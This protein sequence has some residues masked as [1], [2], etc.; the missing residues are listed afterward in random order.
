MKDLNISIGK[1]V[2]LTLKEF[3]EL[4]AKHFDVYPK[5]LRDEMIKKKHKQLFSG[6]KVNKDEPKKSFKFTK[7]DRFSQDSGELDN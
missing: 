1:G 3:K 6:T 2:E 7:E 5:D 4:H